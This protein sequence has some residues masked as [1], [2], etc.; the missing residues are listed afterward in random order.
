[1]KY[2]ALVVDDNPEILDNV[3]DHL[4]SMGHTCDL[5]SSQAEARGLFAENRYSYVL[6]DLN[7]PIKSGRP[8]HATNGENLLWTIRRTKGSEQIPIIIMVSQEER[9]LRFATKVIRNGGT[10]NM[11]LK[12]FSEHGR[13]LG[14]AVRDA[15]RHAGSSQRAAKPVRD[16]EPPKTF[17]R[18]ELA[19]YPSRVEL[20]GVK[21][22][23]SEGKS[24]I[25]LILNVL[26]GTD[27]IGRRRSFCGVELAG[28]VGTEGGAQRV[29]GAIRNF[30]SQVQRIM[31][32]E[33]NVTIDPNVDVIINDRLHGYR[34]SDKI[35]VV[36]GQELPVAARGKGRDKKDLPKWILT[37]I[38]K[39]GR[40]RRQQIVERTGHSNSTVRRNLVKLREEGQIVFEGSPRN[41]Y[42]RLV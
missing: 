35:V 37:E 21:V 13:A 15:L 19:F 28:L 14:K 40:V 16:P 32:S 4:E 18:G 23:G 12:P 33:C 41:G 3:K 8:S 20:F 39:S 22:C 31:L 42:W 25:R 24:M 34:F 30:R 26:R 29:A 6:L 9:S 1:M 10:N 36:K 2:H 27:A 7:I 17:E 5:A 11:V 38:K